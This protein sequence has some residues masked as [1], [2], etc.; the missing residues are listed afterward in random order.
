MTIKQAADI[1][2][3]AAKAYEENFIIQPRYVQMLSWN[4]AEIFD[5]K[6]Y[7]VKIEKRD[8]DRFEK[9][10]EAEGTTFLALFNKDEIT[11][12]ERKRF[13]IEDDF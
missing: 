11:E 8:D 10:V 12:E 1:Q 2:K 6:F 7:D 9:S 13:G 4:F 5:P 3:L